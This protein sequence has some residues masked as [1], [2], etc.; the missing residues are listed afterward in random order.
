MTLRRKK[1]KYNPKTDSDVQGQTIAVDNAGARYYSESLGQKGLTAGVYEMTQTYVNGN[2]TEAFRATPADNEVPLDID[3]SITE[4]VKEI[5]D[6]LDRREAFQKAG[7]AH[8]RGYLFSGPPGCGKSSALRLLESRF[9]EKFDGIV[10]VWQQNLSPTSYYETIRKHEPGRPIMLVCEDLDSSLHYF[11]EMI[12]EFLD[13][14]KGLDNFILVATTNNLNVIPDRIKNRPSRIDRIVNVGKPTTKVRRDYLTQLG[15]E[16]DQVENLVN[17]TEGLS[18]AHLKEVVVATHLLGQSLES[19]L[20]RL[21]VSKPEAV[22]NGGVKKKK[23]M[24]AEL[25]VVH[26]EGDP[27]E[28]EESEA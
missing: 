7:F 1:T 10:L 25:A 26:D 20:S 2:P 28:Y 3:S 13:G 18:I 22:V 8:K 23:A 16:A 14:Q 24:V 6:F 9:C 4:I 19:V 17:K 27:D 21:G 5:D 15:V 12:L 11:E